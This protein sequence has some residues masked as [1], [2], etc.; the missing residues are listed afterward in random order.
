MFGKPQTTTLLIFIFV[1]VGGFLRFYNLNWGAPYYF[2]PDERNIASSVN[3]IKFPAQLNPHFFAYGSLPIYTIYTAGLVKNILSFCAPTVSGCLPEN[4][5][6]FTFL[7]KNWEKLNQ[8]SFNDALIIGRLFSAFFSVC[9]ILITFQI[10]KILHSTATGLTAAFFTSTSVGLIQFAHFATFE[11]WLTFFGMLLFLYCLQII[12][13][14]SLKNV[15]AAGALAGVLISIKI[16]HI[17]LL[18][19]PVFSTIYT[20]RTVLPITKIKSRKLKMVLKYIAQITILVVLTMTV[21]FLTN[22]FVLL[23]YPGFKY[24]IIYEK[25]VALGSIDVFYTHEFF[26][27][28]SVFF[29]FLRIYPFLINPLMTILFIPAFIYL[30]WKMFKTKRGVDVLLVCGYL[31]LLLSSALLFVKWTRYMVPTIPFVYLINALFLSAL[32]RKL[33][34]Y[35]Y[36]VYTLFIILIFISLLSAFSFYRTVLVSPDTRISAASWAKKNLTHRSIA[37]SEAYDIG[38]VAFYDTFPKIIICDLYYLNTNQFPCSG[39]TLEQAINES[40]YII[41]PSERILK[42]SLINK[43]K[44]PKRYLYYKSLF[45][46]KSKFKLVYKTPCDLYCKILYLGDPLYSFEQTASVFDHPT[47]YIF[48]KNN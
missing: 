20:L 45:G 13:Q 22:P 6:S 41:L 35:A 14:D 40:G 39:M 30:V 8:V 4:L 28:T 36:S 46:S 33:N 7:S 24:G 10:G 34:R 23:D 32:I 16:S 18:L 19:L 48:E 47:I 29:Q 38:I 2:H 15:I 1:I 17:V 31:L 12:K 5:S 25:D 11:I 3:Q 43:T 44:F 27:T 21:Y 26:T 9:L 37:L 42:P